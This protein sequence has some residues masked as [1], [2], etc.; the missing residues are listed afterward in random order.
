[1]FEIGKQVVCIKK[2]PSIHKG[3]VLTVRD[4]DSSP[5]A[6]FVKLFGPS[7]V[8]LRF[9]EIIIN[10]FRRG[11]EVKDAW[12]LSVYFRPCKPQSIEVFKRHRLTST[13]RELRRGC[14]F[15]EAIGGTMKT[16]EYG[17]NGNLSATR[18]SASS[19]STIV[20]R[21]SLTLV[22]SVLMAL[23]IIFIFIPINFV[24][25]LWFAAILTAQDVQRASRKISVAYWS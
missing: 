2:T 22:S 23:L 5:P 8:G 21:V 14:T 11:K 3:R 13:P 6:R 9:D 12:S 18:T 17:S 16:Q 19:I 15:A 20:F 7:V 4:I 24:A 10:G 25:G 1:M